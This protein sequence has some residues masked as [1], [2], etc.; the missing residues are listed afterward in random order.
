MNKDKYTGNLEKW[1]RKSIK[2]FH[3]A[4]SGYYSGD[5]LS[6]VVIRLSGKYMTG[7]ILDI[8]AGS[9]ALIDKIPSA[10]GMD[11]VS[12]HKRMIKADVSH[13]PFKDDSFNIIF[14][15]EIIEHLDNETLEEGIREIHRVLKI[16][17]KIIIT[18][19]N[20]ENLKSNMVQ[21]PHCGETFHR[22]GHMQVFDEN[23]VRNL[24]EIKG[25]VVVKI[26]AIPFGF[27]VSHKIL[28]YFLPLLRVIR[29]IEAPNIFVIAAKKQL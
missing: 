14:A 21:C 18:V 9:G 26:E 28:K 10:I 16:D 27:M 13:I 7:C 24:L 1:D 12:K 8:G 25:F 20:N 29:H 4:Y 22:W 2:K 15:T 5:T 11:L 17:G 23:R 19:P 3:E 6:D